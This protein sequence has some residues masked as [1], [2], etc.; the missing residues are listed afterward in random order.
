MFALT[1]KQIKKEI[2]T[3]PNILSV[4]RVALI[5]IYAYLYLNATE[6]KD[7]YVAAAIMAA[8]MI[9][10]FFDGIIAR[11]CNMISTL[12][13]ILDP[14]ADK[15]T[16]LAVLICLATRFTPLLWVLGIFIA[17]ELFMLTMGLLTLSKGRML[18]GALMAGKIC[19]AVLFVSMVI[20]MVLP[21]MSNDGAI[22]IAVFDIVAMFMSFW[23]YLSTYMGGKHGISIVKLRKEAK[24]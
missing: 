4:V 2:L 16:Q 9:T 6:T 22:I 18:D 12:G 10:D 13:K 21:N 14:V 1:K 19:T 23:F 8:S 15:L 5:P 11:K 17:K 24:K 3:I 20:L 7:Y